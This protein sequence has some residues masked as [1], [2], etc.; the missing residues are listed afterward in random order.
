[1][2]EKSQHFLVSRLLGEGAKSYENSESITKHA[3]D[4]LICDTTTNN[5]HEY[6]DGYS[7]GLNIEESNSG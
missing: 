7:H 5:N 6:G 3:N 4:N 2:S 1:M